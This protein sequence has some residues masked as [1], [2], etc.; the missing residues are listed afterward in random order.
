MP[1]KFSNDTDKQMLYTLKPF[2][3]SRCIKASFYTIQNILD[4]FSAKGFRRQ[5]SMK[6]F[7]EYK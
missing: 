6:S 5:I 3:R 1:L 2:K 4:L 7:Y